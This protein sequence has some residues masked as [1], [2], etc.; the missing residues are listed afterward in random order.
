M[1]ILVTSFCDLCT[2]GYYYFKAYRLLYVPPGLTFKKFC[3][4]ITLHLYDLFG[5]QKKQ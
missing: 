1:S 4:L 2:A 3:M 5:S